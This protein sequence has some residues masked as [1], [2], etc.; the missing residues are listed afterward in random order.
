MNAKDRKAV[1]LW[2]AAPKTRYAAKADPMYAAAMH[3]ESAPASPEAGHFLCSIA[4]R[5]FCMTALD[6]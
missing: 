1:A 5:S 4:A 3:A 2:F 6:E